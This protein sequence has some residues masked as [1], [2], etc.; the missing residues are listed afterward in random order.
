MTKIKIRLT[1]HP[2][3]DNDTEYKVY[4]EKGQQVIHEVD[5]A[6]IDRL[7][8]CGARYEIVKDEPKKEPAK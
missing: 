7:D 3:I 4:D 2:H 5:Q 1:A 8:L 6:F